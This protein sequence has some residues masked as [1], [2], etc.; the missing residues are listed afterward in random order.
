MHIPWHRSAQTTRVSI[1]VGLLTVAQQNAVFRYLCA[2]VLD[3]CW[4]L[5][6]HEVRIFETF[7][8][9]TTFI[10]ISRQSKLDWQTSPWIDVSE[11]LPW[12]H[13]HLGTVNFV[14]YSLF[15]FFFLFLQRGTPLC[16]LGVGSMSSLQHGP[17][18]VMFGPGVQYHTHCCPPWWQGGCWCPLVQQR[19][20]GRRLHFSHW[21][22]KGNLRTGKVIFREM[23]AS[24]ACAWQQ[25]DFDQPR[26][27]LCSLVLDG[28]PTMLFQRLWTL[29]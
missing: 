27:K 19:S 25:D 6:L 5:Y 26:Y 22:M 28:Q 29:G 10:E 14:L 24:L 8:S 21:K 17:L 11:L 1:L 12:L 9:L 3:S 13:I 7:T 20:P 15:F 18:A 2:S 23:C 4:F 16:V